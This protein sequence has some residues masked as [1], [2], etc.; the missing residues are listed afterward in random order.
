MYKE[1]IS[2]SHRVHTHSEFLSDRVVRILNNPYR[3]FF[4]VISP[5]FYV[6]CEGNQATGRCFLKNVILSV[7]DRHGRTGTPGDDR[8]DRASAYAES[9][10]RTDHEI[11]ICAVL[12]RSHNRHLSHGGKRIPLDSRLHAIQGRPHHRPSRKPRRR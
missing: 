5:S 8:R 12:C 4:G 6:K 7:L 2:S 9:Q 11:R 3:V 10:P 1:L